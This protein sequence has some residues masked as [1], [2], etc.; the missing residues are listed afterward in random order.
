MRVWYLCMM[1]VRYATKL[2]EDA[3]LQCWEYSHV[4]LSMDRRVGETAALEGDVPLSCVRL[5]GSKRC[6]VELAMCMG[7]RA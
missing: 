1:C 2:A 3:C 5:V 7:G 4:Y 6:V